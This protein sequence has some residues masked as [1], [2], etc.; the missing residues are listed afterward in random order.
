M[1]TPEPR[2]PGVSTK[3]A[4]ILLGTSES[5]IRRR[6]Q[7]GD[8]QAEKIARPGGTLLRVLLDA[9]GAAPEPQPHQSTAQ[10]PEPLQDAPA[11]TTR[12]LEIVSAALESER[13]ERQILSAEIRNLTERAAR[14]E[15]RAEVAEARATILEA[16]LARERRGW[17]ARIRDALMG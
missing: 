9:P 4:A 2:L 8:L 1:P 13:S 5:D 14:A 10:A 16:E 7:R 11:A 3:E 6:I 15:T 17:L 12:A